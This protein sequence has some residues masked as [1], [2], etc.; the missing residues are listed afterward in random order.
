MGREVWNLWRCS[1]DLQRTHNVGNNVYTSVILPITALFEV[2]S[3]CYGLS[4]R[5]VMV[6]NDYCIQLFL[7]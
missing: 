3:L 5:E 1:V 7:H 2:L 4:L 6:T